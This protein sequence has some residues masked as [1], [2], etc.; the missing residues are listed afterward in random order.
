LCII[1]RTPDL[2]L[3]QEIEDAV[4]TVKQSY[5]IFHNIH[6]PKLYFELTVFYIFQAQVVILGQDI[7]D[8]VPT[9]KQ[10]QVKVYNN[11][12]NHNNHITIEKPDPGLGQ[13]GLG[14]HHI[15]WRASVVIYID[16]VKYRIQ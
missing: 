7:E 10:S 16:S 11:H 3:N 13:N 5:V 14:V 2:I 15:T 12:I 4:P 1:S 9:D 8:V 6:S